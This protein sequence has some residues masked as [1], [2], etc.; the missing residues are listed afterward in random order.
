[1]NI[2][3]SESVMRFVKFIYLIVLLS[4]SNQIL[5]EDTSSKTNMG[6]ESDFKNIK[7]N[8]SKDRGLI[9]SLD[10]LTVKVGTDIECGYVRDGAL[11][12]S[13]GVEAQLYKC[14]KVVFNFTGDVAISEDSSYLFKIDSAPLYDS[15][16]TEKN[17]VI[18]YGKDSQ[19][20]NID[21]NNYFVDWYK[22]L[23]TRTYY[24]GKYPIIE[25]YVGYRKSGHTIKAGR[26]KTV[27]GFDDAEM[28]WGDDAKFAPIQHWLARDLFSGITYSYNYSAITATGAIYSGGNPTKG[29]SNYLNFVESPDLKSNNTPTFAGRIEYQYD[30]NTQYN[31]YLYAS[32]LRN[33][34]GSTWVD[35]LKDGKRNGMIA[36][37]GAVLNILYDNDY[38]NSLKIFAQYTDYVSGLKKESSQ[39]QIPNNKQFKNIKQSGYFVGA[40]SFLFNNKLNLAAAYEDFARF[41]YNIFAYHDFKLDNTMKNARHKSQIFQ[42]K[43]FFNEALSVGVSYHKVHNVAKHISQILD[44]RKDNRFKLSLYI[45]L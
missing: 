41:D 19:G 15:I 39:A 4:I 38:L 13:F 30:I 1:M 40:E 37:Y 11:Y 44:N 24:L 25:G 34:T 17:P 20:R 27:I 12:A 23:G 31:G 8:L 21:G 18:I 26:M 45:N 43:Y 16:R 14:S 5:A 32:Y 33:I 28:F 36:A 6:Y 3:Y 22:N 42:I 10:N 29:Y 2:K 7:Y 9:L 35:D